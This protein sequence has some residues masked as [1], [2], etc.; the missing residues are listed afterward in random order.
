M[1]HSLIWGTG[2]CDFSHRLSNKSNVI[3]CE[4]DIPPSLDHEAF[5]R[6]SDDRLVDHNEERNIEE[7]V[8]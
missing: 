1:I 3:S 2:K 8:N 6:V 7:E 5:E 4:T